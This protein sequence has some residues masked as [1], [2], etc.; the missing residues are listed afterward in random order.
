MGFIQSPLIPIFNFYEKISALF[1]KFLISIAY[2]TSHVTSQSITETF[3]YLFVYY[4]TITNY[5]L[6]MYELSNFHHVLGVVS[7]TRVSGENRTHDPHANS[8][9]R[10]P[11]R[12]LYITEINPEAVITSQKFLYIFLRSRTVAKKGYRVLS[13]LFLISQK[14][15]ILKYSLM[16]VVALIVFL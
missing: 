5:I 3:I 7:Q 14:I 12:A 11:S 10:C 6:I 1:R 2:V 9:A 8:L 4:N 15:H 13:P 16:A